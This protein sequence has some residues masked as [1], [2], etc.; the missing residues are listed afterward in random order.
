MIV[1]CRSSG[2]SLHC[3]NGQ[4]YPGSQRTNQ[5][6]YVQNGASQLTQVPSIGGTQPTTISNQ[7]QRTY[8]RQDRQTLLANNTLANSG[9]PQQRSVDQLS[10]ERAAALI[11]EA[12]RDR[13]REWHRA[14]ELRMR[15]DELER[16]KAALLTDHDTLKNLDE[17]NKKSMSEL[18]SSLEAEQQRSKNM[19]IF[20]FFLMVSFLANLYLVVHLSKLLQR[21]RELVTTVRSSNSAAQAA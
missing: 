3:G 11:D 9:L 17:K 13:E 21:Y 14:E 7:P 20:P 1:L 15:T 12:R 8:P 16:E 5:P 2:L 6:G 10:D 4:T 18:A 19:S